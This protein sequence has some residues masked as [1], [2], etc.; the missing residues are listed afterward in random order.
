MAGDQQKERSFLRAECEECIKNCKPE[1][2]KRNPNCPCVHFDCPR[3]GNCREC[4][5]YSRSRGEKTS[6]GRS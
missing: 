4:L 6:C 5:A 2:K 1:N 3:H